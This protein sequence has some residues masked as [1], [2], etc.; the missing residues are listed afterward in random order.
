VESVESTP[1]TRTTVLII[2]DNYNDRKHWSNALRGP[3][4]NYLVLEASNA[5]DGRTILQNQKVDCVLL[6]FDMSLCGFFALIELV[7]DLARPN[8]LSSCSL[9]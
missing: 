8:I 1:P 5:E 3:S 6:D 2:D 4:F 7:P 9:V